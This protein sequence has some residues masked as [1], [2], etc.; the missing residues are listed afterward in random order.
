MAKDLD[1][2]NP[3]DCEV[4]GRIMK[5]AAERSLEDARAT[6]TAV[7]STGVDPDHAKK[8]TLI[9]MLKAATILASERVE[10]ATGKACT[11]EELH[12]MACSLTLTISA[13]ETMAVNRRKHLQN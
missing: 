10:A 9:S 13:L 2:T 3:A 5:L 12:N 8:A 7:V 1:P 4:V 6:I 11:L